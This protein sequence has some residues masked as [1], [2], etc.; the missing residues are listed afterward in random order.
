MALL[1]LRAVRKTV[2]VTA[3]L[4]LLAGLTACG[5]SSTT[6]SASESATTQAALGSVEIFTPSDG[7]TLS[8]RTPLNTWGK[9][10]PEITSSLREQG[11]EADDIDAHTADSLDKQSRDIQD[12]VVSQVSG[13]SSSSSSSA[14][15]TDS[16][17]QDSSSSQASSSQSSSASASSS[18][19]STT[20]QSTLIIAPVV[21]H[22]TISHQ[23]GDLVEH[24][25]TE[26]TT[27]AS[28]TTSSSDDAS[29]SA[30]SD[31]SSSAS[32]D[33]DSS[34]QSSDSSSDSQNSE[35][36]EAVQRLRSALQLAQSSG[37]H[38]I[39]LSSTIEGFTPD[40]LVRMSTARVIG[41]VQAQQLVSK[42]AL[43]K[44]TSD[45]PKAVEVLLP[46]D[47]SSATSNDESF[48]KN[49]F[50][51]IWEVLQ[52]YFTK[53]VVTSPSGKLSKDTTEDD[54]ESLTIDA[55]SDQSIGEA[56]SDRLDM[57]SVNGSHTG[58]DGIIALNDYVASGVIKQLEDLGY[59]GSSADINPSISISGIVNNI[60]GKHDLSKEAVPEPTKK[61]ESE[62]SGED[63]VEAVNSRWPIVTGYGAYVELMP[64]I[65]DGKLWMTALE[66]R[67]TYA[68][69]IAAVT[70][71][72]SV[73]GSLTDFKHVS[74]ETINEAQVPVIQEDL[75]AVSAS[76]L[77]STLIDTGYISLADAGL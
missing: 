6:P 67:Q 55:T 7:I 14:T 44:A 23:Y 32:G 65:V 51:G 74:E 38:V 57:T 66:N 3:S 72:L 48:A 2:A 17:S 52:P 25:I 49:A 71:Q 69:D 31:A 62:S 12:Y 34:S 26:T 76:N 41:S 10:V 53:G 42:L 20:A 68:S 63:A 40:A 22:S 13:S 8:Q 33:E 18:T 11:Y 27:D 29:A 70:K 61:P 43:D 5:Q 73:G 4:V 75:L 56:V 37:M 24:D 46:Y 64:H 45:N 21:S 60:T 50:A 36:N 30:S 16:S 77:K 9:L 59:T 19:D 47:S 15:P 58:I 54:W 28:D 39:L 35:Y 1:D